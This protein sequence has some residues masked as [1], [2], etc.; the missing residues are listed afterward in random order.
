MS[1]DGDSKPTH[2]LL[3]SGLVVLKPSRS[4]I[5]EMEHRLQT[6]PQVETYRFPDQDFL[7]SYYQGR[8]IPLPYVYNGLKKLRTVH[9][10]LWRD[11]KVKNVHYI[12]NKPWTA[13]LEKDDV[14]A[15]THQWWWDAY[16][17]RSWPA[18]ITATS[19]RSTTTLALKLG[20]AH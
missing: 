5:A 2:H 11:D 6:D 10:D 12:I 13:V 4:I 14:D 17:L 9:P 1:I 15:V 18:V 7:A 3:N 20:I 16:H 19:P 8:L